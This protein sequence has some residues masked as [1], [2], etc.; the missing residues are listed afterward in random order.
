MGANGSYTPNVVNVANVNIDSSLVNK[1]IYLQVG[2][3]VQVVG[4]VQPLPESVGLR[5]FD[6]NIDLPIPSN[7]GESNDLTGTGLA[8]E[9]PNRSAVMVGADT[10]ANQA[11]ISVI[12]FNNNLSNNNF[13]VS[14]TFQ[15]IVN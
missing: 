11:R 10:D 5:T 15:Y 14:Y 4:V 1:H 9:G 3:V 13:T 12:R 6:F 8:W 2:S 7:F